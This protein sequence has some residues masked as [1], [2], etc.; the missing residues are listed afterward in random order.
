[1]NHKTRG[2][3]LCGHISTIVIHLCRFL[4]QHMCE[5][6]KGLEMNKE[7]KDNGQTGSQELAILLRKN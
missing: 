1:M 6:I 2:K 7:A 3:S 4:L 5:K